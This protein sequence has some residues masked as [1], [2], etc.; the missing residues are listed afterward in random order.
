[1][2]AKNDCLTRVFS[3][4]I[5][6]FRISSSDVQALKGELVYFKE[7]KE[8][9]AG[10]I[11]RVN[12]QKADIETIAHPFSIN[13]QEN[14]IK[15][16]EIFYVEPYQTTLSFDDKGEKASFRAKRIY[17]TIPYSIYAHYKVPEFSIHRDDKKLDEILGEGLA[18]VSNIPDINNLERL[19]AFILKYHNDKLKQPPKYDERQRPL[20]SVLVSNEGICRHIAGLSYLFLKLHDLSPVIVISSLPNIDERHSFLYATL[21]RSVYVF[22]PVNRLVVP[23]EDLIETLKTREKPIKYHKPTEKMS[24]VFDYK[25]H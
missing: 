3:Q 9:I 11:V 8:I 24:F 5:E 22:D 10:K 14:T 17:L 21:N 2:T 13:K 15:D 12:D 7:D 19:S 18:E 1:M 23:K 4:L 20:G 6:E 16:V 25:G